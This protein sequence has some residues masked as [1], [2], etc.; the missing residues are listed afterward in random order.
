MGFFLLTPQPHSTL[1]PYDPS[2]LVSLG[3]FSDS[4]LVDG[5]AGGQGKV[6][7]NSYKKKKSGIL[8]SPDSARLYLWRAGPSAGGHLPGARS[9]L[10]SNP[11]GAKTNQ[12]MRAA[13]ISP[14]GSLRIE[15]QIFY[16]VTS[17]QTRIC[18]YVYCGALRG[19][20]I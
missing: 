4:D 18:K 7:C 8:C 10:S 1:Q 9:V 20:L 16:G 6:L 13:E 15:N 12:I 3:G 19:F 14:A 11:H 17:M 5:T 2:V